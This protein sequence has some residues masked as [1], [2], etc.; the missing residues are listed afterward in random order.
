MLLSFLKGEL[1]RLEHV[2]EGTVVTMK[3]LLHDS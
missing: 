1:T 2:L 3:L